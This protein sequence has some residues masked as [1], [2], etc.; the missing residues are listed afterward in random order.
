VKDTT[1]DVRGECPAEYLGFEL[2]KRHAE[3]STK[4]RKSSSWPRRQKLC[5]SPFIYLRHEFHAFHVPEN[6]TEVDIPGLRQYLAA[7]PQANRD[8]PGDIRPKIPLVK[9]VVERSA[10]SFHR[11]GINW[12]ASSVYHV[13][14][15]EENPMN[16][17]EAV[18]VYYAGPVR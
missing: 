6:A 7:A 1:G 8:R 15:R 2:V 16:L 5:R 4:G 10:G 11:R 17:V 12:A 9:T 3:G 13:V 14:D 18:V